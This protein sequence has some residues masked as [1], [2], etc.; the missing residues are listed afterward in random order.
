[1]VT[2]D[3]VVRRNLGHKIRLGEGPHEIA[4][5]SLYLDDDEWGVLCALLAEKL[6]KVRHLVTPRQGGAAIDE[7]ADGTLLAEIDDQDGAL[8]P[9]PGWLDVLGDVTDGEKWPGARL[10]G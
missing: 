6:R 5:T 1:V 3:G 4:C 2:Q 10:V 8:V 7:L 9:V